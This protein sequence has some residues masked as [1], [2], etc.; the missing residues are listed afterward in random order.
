[1]PEL[2][3]SR[4]LRH[5]AER[6]RMADER[7]GVTCTP[8]VGD[9]VLAQAERAYRPPPFLAKIVPAEEVAE[10]AEILHDLWSVD[11]EQVGEKILEVQAYYA[12]TGQRHD[13]TERLTAWCR[14]FFERRSEPGQIDPMD[15]GDQFVRYKRLLKDFYDV[16]DH[17]SDM[18][19]TINHIFI[20]ECMAWVRWYLYARTW[21]RFVEAGPHGS[22]SFTDRQG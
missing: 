3:D 5:E 10:L 4:Q 14:R 16:V 22:V 17:L 2:P 19:G 1:M 20:D 7:L 6:A 12:L 9:R 11:Q 21:G 18:D 8:K 15:R 13:I